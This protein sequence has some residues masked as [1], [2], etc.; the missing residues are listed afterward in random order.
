MDRYIRIK[1]EEK[2]RNK[3]NEG[4]ITNERKKNYIYK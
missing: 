1:D 4:N 3:N 2:E